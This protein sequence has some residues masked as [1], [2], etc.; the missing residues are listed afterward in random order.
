MKVFPE[1]RCAH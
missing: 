1:N